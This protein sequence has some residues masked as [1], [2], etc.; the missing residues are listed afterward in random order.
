M[1]DSSGHIELGMA[2]QALAC[3]QAHAVR[4]QKNQ[5]ALERSKQRP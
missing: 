4:P 2:R 5:F 3:C 1:F